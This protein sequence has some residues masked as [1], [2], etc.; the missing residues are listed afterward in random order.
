MNLPVLRQWLELRCLTLSKL[1]SALHLIH[2]EQSRIRIPSTKSGPLEFLELALD[3]HSGRRRSR[4]SH[5][6]R[7]TV[8]R[9]RLMR[10]LRLIP[11]H[12][13]RWEPACDRYRDGSGH[14]V[15]HSRTM[16]RCSGS[17]RRRR[18]AK[19][20]ASSDSVGGFGI[21][22]RCSVN[23]RRCSSLS[24]PFRQKPIFNQHIVQF[25]HHFGQFRSPQRVQIPTAIEQSVNVI[26]HIQLWRSLVSLHDLNLQTFWMRKHVAHFT[27]SLT[28]FPN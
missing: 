11:V 10:M 2:L 5:R 18:H 27:I 3:H 14:I 9:A 7:I 28:Y 1:G 12:R 19:G 22:C 23:R 13:I 15:F 24:C 6:H 17:S 26:G 20:I 4:R 8:L 16:S 21:D 25:Q